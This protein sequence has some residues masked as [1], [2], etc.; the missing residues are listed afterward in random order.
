MADAG[1]CLGAAVSAFRLKGTASGLKTDARRVQVRLG[2]WHFAF[3][4]TFKSCETGVV[5]VND[6]KSVGVEPVV[7]LAVVGKSG[8]SA[9]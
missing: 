6:G 5:L 9:E 7:F 3:Q 8:V 1:L 2:G 4:V